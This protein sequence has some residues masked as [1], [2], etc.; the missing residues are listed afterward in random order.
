M[1]SGEGGG[2]YL[3]GYGHGCAGGG[4]VTAGLLGKFATGKGI[5]EEPA[6]TSATEV[7]RGLEIS[8]PKNASAN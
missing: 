5:R 3:G 2:R 7:Q 8:E 6:R 1:I 4:V